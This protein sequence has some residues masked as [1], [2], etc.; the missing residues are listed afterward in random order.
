[1]ML[2]SIFID[3]L[4]FVLLLSVLALVRADGKGTIIGIA[5]N[6]DGAAIV[7]IDND[8]EGDETPATEAFIQSLPDDFAHPQLGLGSMNPYASEFTTFVRK[9][10]EAA[11]VGVPFVTDAQ[12]GA[13]EQLTAQP[14]S[15]LAAF[16]YMEAPNGDVEMIALIM[17]IGEAARIV[18]LN[19]ETFEESRQ[20]YVFDDDLWPVM[21]LSAADRGN[22]IFYCVMVDTSDE[23]TL[24]FPTDVT[25]TQIVG[26][27][28]MTGTGMTFSETLNFHMTSLAFEENT[29]VLVGMAAMV[30]G[31]TLSMVTIEPLTHR[32]TRLE[33]IATELEGYDDGSEDVFAYL[34]ASAMDSYG[35]AGSFVQ[36][37]RH[38][39][40]GSDGSDDLYPAMHLVDLSTSISSDTPLINYDGALDLFVLD[41]PV[42]LELQPDCGPLFGDTVVT[43]QGDNLVHT[44][45]ITCRINGSL[46]VDGTFN[47]ED[48]SVT[49]SPPPFALSGAQPIEVA[50][51]DDH[52]TDPLEYYYYPQ[53]RVRYLSPNWG[54][55]AGGTVVYVNGDNLFDPFGRDGSTTVN[56]TITC[57]FGD[58]S[59]IPGSYDP[60]SGAVLC[61]SP[62]FDHL[63]AI[64]LEVALNGQQY[65]SN[66]ILFN[67]YVS[68]VV[69]TSL[70]PAS[71]EV[72]G[73]TVVLV[74][75]PNFVNTGDLAICMF[76]DED[77]QVPATWD[78]DT[79]G[80]YCETPTC[81]GVD[82]VYSRDPAVVDFTLLLNGQIES[83]GTLDY[84]F[85]SIPTI[86]GIEPSYG[87]FTGETDVV[88]YGTNFLE[89]NEIMVSFGDA[90]PVSCVVVVRE[91]DDAEVNDIHCTTPPRSD[92]LSGDVTVLVAL[93]GQQYRGGSNLA[94]V[95]YYVPTLETLVPDLGPDYGDSQVIV[96]GH[97]ITETSVIRCRFGSGDNV[98]VTS[99]D[100]Y[101]DNSTVT[102]FTPALEM[103]TTD[104]A[105]TGGFYEIPVEITIDNGVS[106]S[107][108]SPLL[109][110][111][112]YRAPHVSAIFVT[113]TTSLTNS[114]LG[115]GA[116]LEVEG[117]DFQN[118]GSGNLLCM[119]TPAPDLDGVY[120][121][122]AVTSAASYVSSSQM[123][124]VVPAYV[125]PTN[126]YVEIT[127][128][129][130]DFTSDKNTFTFYDSEVPPEVDTLRP[131]S[132]PFI[133]GITVTLDGSNFADLDSL[134]CMYYTENPD[135][136]IG[137]KAAT[138]LS[139]WQV[140]CPLA[141]MSSSVRQ[142]IEDETGN[143][144]VF[145][146]VAVSNDDGA[147]WSTDNPIFLYS[148]TDPDLSY[149][150]DEDGGTGLS[151]AWV[152]VE[153]GFT[154][155]AINEAGVAQMVEGDV[156]YVEFIGGD[157]YTEF[158]ASSIIYRDGEDGLYDVLYTPT[159][160]G[161]FELHITLGGDEICNPVSGCIWEPSPMDVYIHYGDL[162]IVNCTASGT[163]LEGSVAAVTE[164]IYIQE[165]DRFGNPRNRHDDSFAGE[166]FVVVLYGPID[167]E[168]DVPAELDAVLVGE[169]ELTITDMDVEYL[170]EGQYSTHYNKVRSGWYLLTVTLDD[171]HI[172]GSPFEFYIGPD[173]VTVAASSYAYGDGIDSI[174][175]G[176][177]GYFV[178]QAGDLYGNN[179]TD[180]YDT[181]DVKVRTL[182]SSMSATQCSDYC[183]CIDCVAYPS[184]CPTATVTNRYDG[185][186]FVQYNATIAA[187]YQICVNL[188]GGA[189][190]EGSPFLVEVTPAETYT[191]Y[192][193]A[194]GDGISVG[195]AGEETTFYLQGRDSFQNDKVTG[196]ATFDV[197]IEGYSTADFDTL[198]IIV[199]TKSV[200]SDVG[201]QYEISYTLN[202]TGYYHVFV[203]RDGQG[204]KDNP[205]TLF[206]APGPASKDTSYAYGVGT[207]YA[208]AGDYTTFFVQLV[209][210]HGNEL[211]E[212]GDG[213]ELSARLR[214]N[215]YD[216]A[217]VVGTVIDL[218]DG[219]YQIAYTA[220][221]SGSYALTVYFENGILD[222]FEH[223]EVVP[224]E[225]HVPS[226]TA[227]G[228]GLTFST[229]G[230]V[231]TFTI[232]AR[233][234]YGNLRMSGGDDFWVSISIPYFDCQTFPVVSCE[235]I[236]E[237]TLTEIVPAVT[238]NDDGTYTATYTLNTTLPVDD[239]YYVRI[240][241][242]ST[243]VFGSPFELVIEPGAI[244]PAHSLAQLDAPTVVTAGEDLS[245]TVQTRDQWS[246]NLIDGGRANTPTVTAN[247]YLMSL[248]DNGDGTYTAY[249]L[250]TVTGDYAI[251]VTKND[252]EFSGSP[253]EV[254]VES[255]VT[256]SETSYAYGD[257]ICADGYETL[258]ED[259]C[260]VISGEVSVL[261]LQAR[262]EFG[263]N[264]T[265]WVDQDN[266][267][268]FIRGPEYSYAD[269]V[270]YSAGPTGSYKATW[271]PRVVGN[272][273]LSI[274]FDSP[275]QEGG[276]LSVVG[277]P[278]YT[279]VSQDS[280]NA[281]YSTASGTMYS[282][283]IVAG[284]ERTIIIQARDSRDN[285]QLLGGDTFYIS[286]SSDGYL[287]EP[288][289][290]DNGDGTYTAAPTLVKAGTFT[291]DITFNGVSISAHPIEIEVTPGDSSPLTSY[292]YGN[293]SLMGYV[294]EE[295]VFYIR[296]VDAYGN[297]AESY[298]DY[299]TVTFLPQG[300]TSS[301][302]KASCGVNGVVCAR[303]SSNYD[304]TYSV[305]HTLSSS[306]PYKMYV[307]LQ[308]VD[309]AGSPFL[310]LAEP[311]P[312]AGAYTD[313]D[314]ITYGS[315]ASGEG[316]TTAV[317]GE[318]AYF[319]IHAIDVY[320][321]AR[322]VGG[323]YFNAVVRQYTG[324]SVNPDVTETEVDLVDW[325]N[326]TYTGSYV[327]YSNDG[328][329]Q[330]IVVVGD[331]LD[332]WDIVGS[333]FTIRVVPGETVAAMCTAEGR[334]LSGG[335]TK[336][337]MNIKVQARDQ[338]GNTAEST[339]DDI[340]IQ[341]EGVSNSY[342]AN[343]TA[344]AQGEGLYY[345]EYVSPD[346]EGY[347]YVYVR[348]GDEDLPDSPYLV[349]FLADAYFTVNYES[350]ASGDG[351][352]G[353][354]AGVEASFTI[355]AR[356]RFGFDMTTGYEADREEEFTV[357]LV[358][359]KSG[360]V[361]YGNVVDNSD[362]TYSVYYTVTE[363]GDYS[364]VVSF[365][366]NG[367]SSGV[368]AIKGSPFS[369]L[370]IAASPAASASDVQFISYIVNAGDRE[371]YLVTVNDEF[372]NFV[373][374]N[375]QTSIPQ[376]FQWYFSLDVASSSIVNNRNGTYT[377]SF[378]PTIASNS[379]TV[380]L[381]MNGEFIPLN[382]ESLLELVVLP[383]SSYAPNCY[384]YGNGLQG[385]TASN[386]NP[387]YLYI[388]TVDEFGNERSAEDDISF[389]LSLQ[390]KTDATVPLLTGVIVYS[391]DGQFYGEYIGTVAGTYEMVVTGD[392][393]N[394]IDS[395]FSV[396][397]TA[398]EVDA[399]SSYAYGAGTET[400][401]AGETA[402]F[403]IQASDRFGNKLSVGGA[404]FLGSVKG[405]NSVSAYIYD[406]KVTDKADGTYTGSYVA[407][408]Q[409]DYD[410]VV[411]YNGKAITPIDEYI[412]V[413][414]G[415]A[416]PSLCTSSGDGLVGTDAGGVA[417]FLVTTYDQYKSRIPYGGEWIVA[418]FDRIANYRGEDDG[419]T[420]SAS[421]NATDNGD[422][423]YRFVYSLTR[424]GTYEMD[425]VIYETAYLSDGSV[426]SVPASIKNSPFTVL[427][428]PGTTV[429]SETFAEGDGT[430]SA[431][432]GIQTSILVTS[433]DVYGNNAVYDP[434]MA[435]DEFRASV[436]GPELYDED[437]VKDNRDGTY[438]IYYTAYTTG[439]YQLTVELEN[440]DGTWSEITGTDGPSPFSVVV[441]SGQT[442]A[443]NS[444]ILGTSGWSSGLQSGTS[445]SFTIVAK[446]AF[447]NLVTTGGD[448]FSTV[449]EATVG[450]GGSS[451][452]QLIDVT[453]VDNGDGTYTCSMVPDV[454]ATYYVTMYLGTTKL[455]DSTVPSRLVI[456][457]NAETDASQ[458]TLVDY[459]YRQQPTGGLVDV[460]SVYLI[461][462]R[463]S[464]G[465][466][467]SGL[468][469]GAVYVSLQG[470]E[471]FDT[472]TG[473]VISGDSDEFLD[474]ANGRIS[475]EYEEGIGYK[476]SF[477]IIVAGPYTL[478]ATI[479]GDHLSN[480]PISLRF[481]DYVGVTDAS[482]SFVTLVED[483]DSNVAGEISYAML[484][485]RNE[486]GI[487]QASGGDNVTATLVSSVLVSPL[488]VS[489]VDLE[490]GSYE[491]SYVS[492]VAAAFDLFVWINGKDISN[493][494]TRFSIVPN[495]P[496]GPTSYITSGL[497]TSVVNNYKTLKL[498]AV[499]RYGN[500]L[501]TEP[502]ELGTD[503]YLVSLEV[504][505]TGTCTAAAATRLNLEDDCT[506]WQEPLI[507]FNDDGTYTITYDGTV[508]G[509]YVFDISLNGEAIKDSAL[510]RTTLRPGTIDATQT[511]FNTTN[512]LAESGV[513]VYFGII[514]RD[515][516][517]NNLYS[518]TPSAVFSTVV[519]L[520]GEVK[521]VYV[522][523]KNNNDGTYTGFTTMTLSGNYTLAVY[524]GTTAMQNAIYVS[525]E[526]GPVD[527][528]SC[529]AQDEGLRYSYA[530]QWGEFTIIARDEFG[531]QLRSGGL[532][533]RV[534]MQ[535]STWIEGTVADNS[536]GTYTAM[537]YPVETGVYACSIT[538]VEETADY[539]IKEHIGGRNGAS[540]SP[541]THQVSP[542][543]TN[544]AASIH[545]A[546]AEYTAGEPVLFTI[547]AKDE[548]GAAETSGGDFFF[549]RMT[550]AAVVDGVVTDLENGYYTV[551]LELTKSGEYSLSIT[552]SSTDI[553]DSPYAVTVYPTTTD[554]ASSTVS[555]DVSTVS[556][557]ETGVLYIDTRDVYGNAVTT[558][559]D[560]A[561]LQMSGST[562]TT[563]SRCTD[564][565]NGQYECSYYS[566]VAG[567]YSLT[568]MLN[569]VTVGES[570]YELII[571]PVESLGSTSSLTTVLSSSLGGLA[572]GSARSFDIQARDLY[573]N[574]QDNI[575]EDLF[576]VTLTLRESDEDG[577][578]KFAVI[579][580]LYEIDGGS[581]AAGE[582]LIEDLGD[583]IHRVTFTPTV[584]G[585]YTAT[586]ELDH[587]PLSDSPS[588][589]TLSPGP[590]NA[591]ESKVD[592]SGLQGAGVGEIAYFTIYTYDS[593]GNK[594][595]SGGTDFTVLIS[596]ISESTSSLSYTNY[597][598]AISV[599]DLGTGEYT[600]SYTLSVTGSYALKVLY[601][602]DPLGGEDETATIRIVDDRSTAVASTSVIQGLTT[603]SDGTAGLKMS[604]GSTIDVP[605]QMRT[606]EGVD[607]IVGGAAV[608][609]WLERYDDSD[610]SQIEAEFS[611][612]ATDNDD[613]TYTATIMI[614]E[615]GAFWLGIT[616]K[617]DELSNSPVRVE[618][619]SGDIEPT[620]CYFEDASVGTAGVY[621]EVGIVSVDIYG[622]ERTF[623][624][625]QGQGTFTLSLVDMVSGAEVS[626]SE[627]YITDNFD[628]TFTVYYGPEVSGTYFLRVFYDEQLMTG[629]GI[630]LTVLSGSSSTLASTA[631]GDGIEAG[632]AGVWTNLTIVARDTYGNQRESGGDVFTVAMYLCPEVGASNLECRDGGTAVA[633]A[634]LVQPADMDDG[635]YEAEY[636]V[637]I[638]GE[639]LL[640]INRKD[641]LSGLSAISNSPYRVSISHGPASV[642]HTTGY[643]AGL[644]GG[645]AGE[646]LIFHLQGRDQ[647]GNAV[648]GG[649]LNLEVTVTGSETIRGT[650]I[651]KAD[652]TYA[653]FYMSIPYGAYEIYISDGPYDDDASTQ[654]E[655]SPFSVELLAGAPPLVQTA[656]VANSG[657]S[658]TVVFDTDTDRSLMSTHSSCDQVL[659]DASVAMLY[660]PATSNGPLCWWI[661]DQTLNVNT[662]AGATLQIGDTITLRDGAI[663][664]RL[665][666]SAFL[667]GSVEVSSPD[668]PVTPIAVITPNTYIVGDC[669][670]LTLSASLS[671]GSAGRP[672][673]G[674]SWG[675]ESG[676]DNYR[677]IISSLT[678]QSG[679]V[680][681]ATGILTG[682]DASLF[683][684]GDL[685]TPGTGV[686]FYLTVA[687]WLGA[688]GSTSVY[689]ERTEHILPELRIKGSSTI[690]I[691]R[692]RETDVQAEAHYTECNDGSETFVYE[693]RVLSE[694]EEEVE[695][696]ETTKRTLKLHLASKSLVAGET[697]LFGVYAYYESD[698]TLSVNA[699]VT[700]EVAYSDLVPVISG[701][702]RTSQYNSS[703][704]LDG[705]QSYDPDESVPPML[706]RWSCTVVGS[707]S[708]PCFSDPAD[709]TMY[710][711]QSTVTIPARTLD[712][713]SYTFTLYVSKDYR[714]EQDTAVTIDIEDSVFPI[715]TLSTNIV[716]E[717]V[718][719]DD[720]VY[721][722]GEATDPYTGEIDDGSTFIY[723]WKV[724]KGSFEIDETTADSSLTAP[725]LVLKNNVLDEGVEY[726]V[727]LVVYWR[728]DD[729]QIDYD[730]A[731]GS[732]SVTF[733]TNR[734]PA[735]GLFTVSPTAGTE[736]ITEF[737]VS[738]KYW[739]DD[740]ED[741][742]FTYQYR[743]SLDGDPENAIPLSET[744]KDE[745]TA[746]LP[747]GYE[748]TDYVIY[749]HGY[750][751]DSR[752]S[753]TDVQTVAVTVGLLED[754]TT[755]ERS[756]IDMEVAARE[757]NVLR[758][759]LQAGRS[760]YERGTDW[761]DININQ[762]LLDVIMSTLYQSRNLNDFDGLQQM[763]TVLGQK[764]ART[765]DA[766]DC[767]GPTR[768][769]IELLYHDFLWWALEQQVLTKGT[770]LS[771]AAAAKSV[772]YEPCQL[773]EQL[774]VTSAMYYTNLLGQAYGTGFENTAD[775]D[776][777]Y[778]LSS[779][780]EARDV[781]S[782]IDTWQERMNVST[783][784]Q[785]MVGQLTAATLSQNVPGQYPTKLS[786]NLIDMISIRAQKI[787][788]AGAS[789]QQ[790]DGAVA[791]QLPS[792]LFN[793]DATAALMSDCDHFDVQLVTWR[794][795]PHDYVRTP[796]LLS[797]VSG[798]DMTCEDYIN[799]NEVPIRGLL[800]SI[801][802]KIEVNATD[803]VGSANQQA[804]CRYFNEETLLWET[805]GCY[806]VNATEDSVL[807]RCSHATDFAVFVEDSAAVIEV[808]NPM[809]I[810]EIQT[811]FDP[812]TPHTSIMS[813]SVVA[814]YIFLVL[815][816]H[817]RDVQNRQGVKQKVESLL[818]EVEQR[819]KMDAKMKWLQNV[820]TGESKD[821]VAKFGARGSVVPAIPKKPKQTFVKSVDEG[822]L[823]YRLYVAASKVAQHQHM[824]YG[825]WSPVPKS[826]FTRKMRATVVLF[827]ELATLFLCVLVYRDKGDTSSPSSGEAVGYGFLGMLII[828][829]LTDVMAYVM[830]GSAR[831]HRRAMMSSKYSSE[832][833]MPGVVASVAMW[834]SSIIYACIVFGCLTFLF[835]TL[836]YG[837]TFEDDVA[838]TWLIAAMVAVLGEPLFLRPVRCFVEGLLALNK[839][840]STK[841]NP[842]KRDSGSSKVKA[843][844]GTVRPEGAT[845]ISPTAPEN[846]GSRPN[847]S[848]GE[849]RTPRKFAPSDSE[850][851]EP[852][853][854]SRGTPRNRP[855]ATGPTPPPL[856]SAPGP[857][858]NRPRSP[859]PHSG[860]TVPLGAADEE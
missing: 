8:V 802:I 647:F 816:A 506:E 573:Y 269:I 844:K 284:D 380:G 609:T 484:Q 69:L 107:E 701:G 399:S 430:E 486:Y 611:R 362:G 315:T 635:T 88:L 281:T 309:I 651:D 345:V 824:I 248:S 415:P 805:D 26:V 799:A 68:P 774:I 539:S 259:E 353:S 855:K 693:W 706:Y 19:S 71:G 322:D 106:Y 391:S 279:Y 297:L 100:M 761:R 163:G 643:G 243:E 337:L 830:A 79:R 294:G 732:S 585:T 601:G 172:E 717:T 244:S 642:A 836:L 321:N 354:V 620:L 153:S 747:A 615:T 334:G 97:G 688:K 527:V 787:G 523:Y 831:L 92:G 655:G 518:G 783:N 135:I 420:Y 143:S 188:N 32:V 313:L 784:V 827:T 56:G 137:E 724:I 189:S 9:L 409:G 213:D 728:G 520:V 65:T 173:D 254:T 311:G 200:E 181:W 101:L 401:N 616:Y 78:E 759:L 410:L 508:A 103:L 42:L 341:I 775:S 228:D 536:D 660:D 494:P 310:Y 782:A 184:S 535:G 664:T 22:G 85:Y 286:I 744:A 758:H 105:P 64:A 205:F 838:Q 582:G 117:T 439:S 460:P 5:H 860:K 711:D 794:A 521:E 529:L 828:M 235:F 700:I 440:D 60:A 110:F 470:E 214:H 690:S 390:H 312:P 491:L 41:A 338:W 437:K 489:I 17:R 483:A 274:Q 257:G 468:A 633:T 674:Y 368:G 242:N 382:G 11:S 199:L 276:F 781:S 497:S 80:Y 735:G 517:G 777:L 804:V 778:S 820:M 578:D 246:N 118:T 128:N 636:R 492:T 265:Y 428:E 423:T 513:R 147:T 764:L 349:Q 329:T 393:L 453:I 450:L 14:E 678:S 16:Q 356:N 260:S 52:Y 290:V 176:K 425:V 687:N 490:D 383:G 148:S 289:I 600:V 398:A 369:A 793:N 538:R 47:E 713:G 709:E 720:K 707:N 551:S 414:P 516:F 203:T 204:I 488:E 325:G 849:T 640:D 762:K 811:A 645:Y 28:V 332:R 364:I 487:D 144:T 581:V 832:E 411:T 627:R 457:P 384:A 752:G 760:S 197:K 36:M 471:E 737:V 843:K 25:R 61:E 194:F 49:C 182:P 59:G 238:D 240:G 187:D 271:Y 112:Y 58:I 858:D 296:S 30:D 48:R 266:F 550:G 134:R 119:F 308:G 623:S 229:A 807:C 209:D 727:G 429:A 190:I 375:D 232:E 725:D 74:Y 318:I 432:A 355:Q 628:G 531:N 359:V 463:D 38:V 739:A 558:G 544:A 770:L 474:T 162:A 94:N 574:K 841:S 67:L 714:T 596:G 734:P 467:Q 753:R 140:D 31:I 21:G 526:P 481:V 46:I 852:P 287:L 45:A 567:T 330:L 123:Q 352:D 239:F 626:Q 740:S 667:S 454:A 525:V 658:I 370:V 405:V 590:T 668:S 160:S 115:G 1:M 285:D 679:K 66:S 333:P 613:G 150:E 614:E 656:Q 217:E 560:L 314:G 221:A 120:N 718:N 167:Y 82:L 304:G 207:E 179:R 62:E 654:I 817:Y 198:G 418:N 670:N 419:E 35:D 595:T 231:A 819:Q 789:V 180:G 381:K 29:G 344:E 237:T 288:E 780:L 434:Y 524:M 230:E 455:F 363:A 361:S 800:D 477:T 319:N 431:V 351:L 366:S 776:I 15:L 208:V 847:S 225:T 680:D 586:I 183:S 227:T 818:Q 372:G 95:F 583:G 493:S 264:A 853:K 771:L 692:N 268:V 540:M 174:V 12:T 634:Y 201:G 689:I 606:A 703:F 845:P 580:P 822:S 530:G 696:D 641:P 694:H 495:V 443:G 27:D 77:H 814:L 348:V 267:Q 130:Q 466:L 422:G 790:D 300:Y 748:D 224:S 408:K 127:M 23:A 86:T 665:R 528:Q 371:T 835:F 261:I 742:P 272:Y 326:G 465:N 376:S 557:G 155:H 114:D 619:T 511:V 196:G 186:Y 219:T 644:S 565:S 6:E 639:Y 436:V 765:A 577:N 638:I 295:M 441:T 671:T 479:G 498:Q 278:Y 519:T 795:N 719:A 83:E 293:Y 773:S 850:D 512:V 168:A 857:S 505:M 545:T 675:V 599:Q 102:C 501:T 563:T 421:F 650:V 461:R 113:G 447:D 263:N 806:A 7:A 18:S 192:T 218:S 20:I 282:G 316:T 131:M 412:H 54:P 743:Y 746:H 34:Y 646:L 99:I 262:D 426:S 91:T 541:F 500:L 839:K 766:A 55:Q 156:F 579:Y 504:T 251:E 726:T 142:Q 76:G 731:E 597:D 710:Q 159:R 741:M 93:N 24:S 618:V 37:L 533:F 435:S 104:A 122:V 152:G 587:V 149:A 749:L 124:C 377:A 566:E 589:F 424:S 449:F 812:S 146:H 571:T 652:G 145:A 302:D 40:T 736:F 756:A 81:C 2:K 637:D 685:L 612:T 552:L 757:A 515:K 253:F 247:G 657:T 697:Y 33:D 469:S 220:T 507:A 622:N 343:P 630:E 603:L 291:L 138:F 385:M 555:G 73:G 151:E 662:V 90:E 280:T 856:D 202:K 386:T 821:P 452:V 576:S 406:V 136:V 347:Y 157:I 226:S 216:V 164:N 277:S 305:Y 738:L 554:P 388:Q 549:V 716:D 456:T 509:T 676:V 111:R 559:G 604:A 306:S 591:V 834:L 413:Y 346:D 116:V 755:A 161:D 417:Q 44:D 754:Y 750:V 823:R 705:R 672:F 745:V 572:V 108:T 763:V 482:Q 442:S 98:Y 729:G 193:Y 275:Y 556:A 730:R 10:D 584:S 241:V 191:P 252:V 808:L 211:L 249:A 546:E 648:T 255:A 608:L 522:G 129:G 307:R 339:D 649:G 170:G 141:A 335:Q 722:Y 327:V 133:G 788:V 624:S 379:M 547:E 444:E 826:G 63:N 846:T 715:V 588:S 631:E 570:P 602:G 458:S 387:T 478:T 358:S 598:S 548:F 751:L 365:S 733:S 632:M 139:S 568:L 445:I 772:M 433:R 121:G 542:G 663:R 158:E 796:E 575:D 13:T 464:Y 629:G 815:L 473:Q 397:I 462:T 813:G 779:I 594:K 476:V 195:I 236:G 215:D 797:S 569:V 562:G 323:D 87:P 848:R 785:R 840:E 833:K 166:D 553:S 392:G 185:S 769:L 610:N 154:I 854:S 53:P 446:D 223:V 666:N 298:Y 212:G 378:V 661:D 317:A 791:F 273:E 683:L 258:D 859:R 496:Y 89:T 256:S 303:V 472:V 534:L 605:I 617:G 499:D 407:T 96:N 712:P 394:I 175:A 367:D 767:D 721:F 396:K 682:G 57:S 340:Q 564:L 510:A 669:Q 677:A 625:R 593:Y 373:G 404:S 245:F 360:T 607:V 43:I 837:A 416:E 50:L 698:P 786:S 702:D 532:V 350:T 233:D 403:T 427:I 829:A 438:T 402:Y 768:D 503:D 485:A 809:K 125:E 70:T 178:I 39:T 206:V 842:H 686:T 210:L 292:I 699:T 691:L 514:G 299:Y 177:G 72:S 342:L 51:M 448:D 543:P 681:A 3:A 132:G 374:W 320:N 798:I 75:G 810:D 336:T 165:R 270:V 653:C 328:T 84:R 723:S 851:E 331:I 171:V 592:G 537:Y 4:V 324:S 561:E 169:S 283:Y 234:I 480:S 704:T 708:I 801:D 109:Y 389:S 301:V 673:Q 451:K 250:L 400:A 621:N 222:Y 792:T 475:V 803:Y 825:I 357:Q 126:V 684:E 395:P 695:L 459:A 659:D 502:V